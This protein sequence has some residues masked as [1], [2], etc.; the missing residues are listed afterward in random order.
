MKK[1]L[2]CAFAFVF[3]FIVVA[4]ARIWTSTSGA[5]IEAE[6]VEIKNGVVVL[7]R[8]DGK[9]GSIKLELLS[10]DD[11]DFL[12]KNGH[13]EESAGPAAG[14][15]GDTKIELL[16]I[17]VAK[18]APRDP[19]DDRH[20]FS[21]QP[22]GTNISLFIAPKDTTIISLDS[23]TS[24]ITSFTDEKQTDLMKK[25]PVQGGMMTFGAG[26]IST[27]FFESGSPNIMVDFNG[28]QRP[29]AGAQKI[30][31]RGTVVLVCGKGSVKSEHKNISLD[32]KGS[33]TVDGNKITIK[34]SE[35]NGFGFSMGDDAAKMSISLTSAKPTDAIKSI[36]FLNASGKEIKSTSTG[37]MSG[38]F[39][40][41]KTYEKYYDLSEEVN[42]VTIEVEAFEGTEKLQIPV[43]IETGLGF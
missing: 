43:D 11:L 16:S 41:S 21:G 38:G 1:I 2:F 31:L 15:P 10:Q 4:E 3:L 30:R 5:K 33:F 17:S 37:S 42:A 6:F 39:M 40:N 32:G 13:I 34:K 7:K 29:A 12:I 28:P 8:E 18:P 36:R 24:K 27:K 20:V 35:G 19:G 14:N 9:T 26:P 25:K 22:E 23:E